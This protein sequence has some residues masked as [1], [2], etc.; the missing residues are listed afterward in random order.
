MNVHEIE[1]LLVED[2]VSD[3]ELTI[4]ALKKHNMANK[5]VH[6]ENGAEALDYLFANGA[7]SEREVK[8][9]P[10]LILLDINMPKVGGIEVL[11]QIKGDERTRKIPVIMLTSSKEDPD[12][13]KC[14]DL[15]ANSYVVKPVGF[16]SFM[17]AV[18]EL[19]MYWMLLNQPSS[20]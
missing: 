20:H 16:E 3:A 10:K 19:G 17:K 12:I 15:G 13:D 18:S 9:V 8:N 2:S 14:Y 5:L 11:K 7:Y 6:L 4:R 1:I